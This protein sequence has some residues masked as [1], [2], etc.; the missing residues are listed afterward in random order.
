ME[1]FDIIEGLAIEGQ[2]DVEVLTGRALWGC[3]TLAWVN[4]KLDA[5]S[6]LAR[7]LDNGVQTDCLTTRSLTTTTDLLVHSGTVMP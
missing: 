2:G 6:L 5:K 3:E 7:L 4:P 1:S